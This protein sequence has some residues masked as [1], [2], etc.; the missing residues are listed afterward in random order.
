MQN[1]SFS[2]IVIPAAAVLLNILLYAILLQKST[3]QKIFKRYVFAVFSIAFL[4]NAIWEILQIPL[5]AEGVYSF[6][7]VLF[8]LLASVADAIMVLLIYF[9]FALVYKKPLWIQDLKPSRIILLILAGAIGAVLAETRHLSIG[10]WSYAETMPVIP[11][12]NTGLSPVLQFMV[13]PF[14]TYTLS[15]KLTKRSLC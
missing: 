11:I 1:L 9:A 13:L 3:Q 6:S 15:F 5:Y 10:T 7:H 4:L 12:L 2:V 14:L 8:C